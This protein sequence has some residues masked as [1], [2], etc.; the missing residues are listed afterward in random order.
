MKGVAVLLMMF[1]SV[2]FNRLNA[3]T[4]RVVSG[5]LRDSS[6]VVIHGAN[7]QLAAGKDTFFTTSNKDGRY[8]FKGIKTSIFTLAVTSMG[9]RAYSGTFHFKEGK[10][11]L[12]LEPVIMQPEVHQLED[13]LVKSVIVP[14]TVKPDTLEYDARAYNVRE[15]DMVEDLLK[16]LPGIEVDKEGNVKAQGKEMTKLRVNGKDFFTND[17]TTFIKQLPANIVSKLQVIEDYGEEAEFTGIKKGEP[18]KMLNLVMKPGMNRGTFG[19]AGVRAATSGIYGLNGGANIWRDTK[20]ISAN[21][22]LNNSNNKSLVSTSS[23][24]SL[25]YRDNWSK[26]LSVN[27]DYNYSSTRSNSA[28]NIYRETIYPFGTIYTNTGNNFINRNKGHNLNLGMN[29]TIA[30]STYLTLHAGLN[31]SK[32]NNNS[33]SVSNQTGAIM[34]DLQTGSYSRQS[35]PNIFGAAFFGHR[36]KKSGRVLSASINLNQSNGNDKQQLT[37]HVVYYDVNT[38]GVVKD[39]VLERLVLTE[40]R[41]SNIGMSISYSE[42]L[43]KRK[44]LDVSYNYNT[45]L[46]NNSLLTNVSKSP[47]RYDYID[48]LSNISEYTFS[49]HRINLSYRYTSKQVN[50]SAGINVQPNSTNGQYTGRKESIH[51]STLNFSPMANLNLTISETSTINMGYNGQSVAPNINQLQP[52]ADSRDLQNIIVG[53][54][55]LKPSFNHQFNLS[56]NKSL[57]KDGAMFM[58]GL[59]GSTIK[60]QVVANVL[61]IRDSVL[62]SLK[63]ETHFENATGTYNIGANYNLAQPL[64]NRKLN[65]DFSG[66]IGNSKNI[67]YA[68]NVKN[69]RTSLQILQAVRAGMNLKWTDFSAGAQYSN[70]HSRYTLRDRTT[71]IVTWQFNVSNTIFFS[72]RFGVGYDVS[73]QI[74]SGYYSSLSNN[75]LY[76]NAY[77]NVTFFKKQTANLRLQ[78]NDLLNQGNSPGRVI[79]ENSITDSRTNVITR[80]L[81]LSFNMR[82]SQFGKKELGKEN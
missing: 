32:G 65:V 34:Q 18:K 40:N 35:S 76:I 38:T 39:S 53:N 68:D 78:F 4:T 51:Y 14:V 10:T 67:S 24:T 43:S 52:V 23:G 6:G 17:V 62:G 41:S 1:C 47:G 22:N 56:Y 44:R 79:S 46:T 58:L 66:R 13:V 45:S 70:Y 69:Y 71:N 77:T 3:Q 16:Q 73:K 2:A 7:L 12:E 55:N 42:P 61:L 19:N 28:N 59:N 20:Q 33:A 49:N 27:A 9:Y 31:Y 5:L 63:Q 48:S 15:G 21:L 72:K 50:Y 11:A 75:P 64:F 30:R 80:Y 37:D 8:T 57:S 26:K 81:L 60:N 74:N 36:F 25:S 54:P 29:Y 82:L